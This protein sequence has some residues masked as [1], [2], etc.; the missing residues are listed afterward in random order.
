MLTLETSLLN[1]SGDKMSI[2]EN[3]KLSE[4]TLKKIKTHGVFTAI[5][6]L[7]T[8]SEDYTILNSALQKYVDDTTAVVLCENFRSD[9]DHCGKHYHTTDCGKN[10]CLHCLVFKRNKSFWT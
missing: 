4:S 1:L 10:N 2:S 9:K 5:H 8:A 6:F 7:D 3:Y